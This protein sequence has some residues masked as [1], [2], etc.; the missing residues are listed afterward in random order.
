MSGLNLR[1]LYIYI[2]FKC[3]ID[4]KGF[5]VFIRGLDPVFVVLVFVHQICCFFFLWFSIGFPMVFLWKFHFTSGM[6][7]RSGF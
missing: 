2:Y 3:S 6:I 7:L 5:L 4:V 1:F